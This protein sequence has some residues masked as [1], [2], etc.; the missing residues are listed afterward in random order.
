MTKSIQKNDAAAS[1]QEL[2]GKVVA[3][4]ASR[5]P[6]EGQDPM[7]HNRDPVPDRTLTNAALDSVVMN[8]ARKDTAPNLKIKRP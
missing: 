7:K 4:A 5:D 3:D 2:M 8:A 6:S 1:T